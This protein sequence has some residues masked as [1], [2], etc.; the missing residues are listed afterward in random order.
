MGE[1]ESESGEGGTAD[2]SAAETSRLERMNASTGSYFDGSTS[3]EVADTSPASDQSAAETSRLERMNAATGGSY[4]GGGIASADG[5]KTIGQQ[6]NAVV[7]AISRVLGFIANPPMAIAMHAVRN[8]D[9]IGKP[10]PYGSTAGRIS[11]GGFVSSLP[12]PNS[13]AAQQ[14]AP[15]QAAGSYFSAQ[16]SAAAVHQKQ[17]TGGAVAV[18]AVLATLAFT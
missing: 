15:R 14:A 17:S 4:F 7:S 12:A 13:F 16:S 6:V 5:G 9:D 3:A 10:N 2:Q 18:L 11:D 8:I 1:N